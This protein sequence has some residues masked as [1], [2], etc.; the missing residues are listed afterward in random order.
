MGY[1]AVTKSDFSGSWFSVFSSYI[2]RLAVDL[3][4]TGSEVREVLGVGSI[5][6]AILPVA[7]LSRYD[8]YCIT[9]P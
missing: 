9:I 8:N 1:N 6:V 4:P 3:L 2:H 7:I 5:P